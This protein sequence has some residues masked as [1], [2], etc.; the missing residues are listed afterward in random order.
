MIH[1]PSQV[2]KVETKNPSSV[3]CLQEE[4]AAKKSKSETEVMGESHA[5][6]LSFFL[7]LSL[8]VLGSAATNTNKIYRAAVGGR[9]VWPVGRLLT[10]FYSLWYLSTPI[11]HQAL[12]AAMV[13]NKTTD[14]I[15]AHVLQPLT[16]LSWRT[17]MN[18]RFTL[19]HSP[20]RCAFFHHG[21]K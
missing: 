16:C 10:P 6:F 19:T 5:L 8:S 2:W 13:S 15:I 17:W 12:F 7:S 11:P 18:W 21:F 3:F 9:R 20:P 14:C 4:P 1:P